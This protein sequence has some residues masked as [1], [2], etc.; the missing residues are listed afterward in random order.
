MHACTGKNSCT[1]VP[2]QNAWNSLQKF[3]FERN[4]S[5]S[6]F[7]SLLIKGAAHARGQ[8]LVH[9]KPGDKVWLHALQCWMHKL[10]F[11]LSP[12]YYAYQQRAHQDN[13]GLL[14]N[15]CIVHY[16]QIA[17]LE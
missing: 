2:L 9:E 13:A 6:T 14:H 4:H 5:A 17:W 12:P 11:Q 8:V 15:V 1:S 3:V 10:P 7:V 16:F